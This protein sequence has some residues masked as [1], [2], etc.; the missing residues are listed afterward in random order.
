M[1]ISMVRCCE[2][3]FHSIIRVLLRTQLPT[4]TIDS[5]SVLHSILMVLI[6]D[7]FDLAYSLL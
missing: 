4:K 5:V 2:A 6:R 1:Q 3:Y 7:D